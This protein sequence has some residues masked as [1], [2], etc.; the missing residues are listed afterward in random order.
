MT[1]IYLVTS[2]CYSDYCVVGAYSTRELAEKYIA[3][4]KGSAPWSDFNEIEEHELDEAKTELE[5]GLIPYDVEMNRDGSVASCKCA[6]TTR[7][8]G[9][10]GEPWELRG[11]WTVDYHATGRFL[12]VSFVWAESEEHAVKV[13]NERRAMLIATN[14][15][16]EK[17]KESIHE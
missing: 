2:G 12:L 4:M 17:E 11:T 6:D 13:T 3:T 10:N 1:A 9:E 16:T 15:W 8:Y 7:K 14:Q 5:R